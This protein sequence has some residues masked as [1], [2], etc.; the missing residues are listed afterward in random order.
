MAVIMFRPKINISKAIEMD[1]PKARASFELG[2][3]FGASISTNKIINN[4]LR[5]ELG[6]CNCKASNPKKPK[7]R[8]GIAISI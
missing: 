8:K 4:N 7:T 3:I 1:F 2:Q 6:K 5:T